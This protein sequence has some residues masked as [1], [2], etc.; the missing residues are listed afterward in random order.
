M[1]RQQCATATMVAFLLFMLFSAGSQAN[2]IQVPP[3]A[4]AGYDQTVKEGQTVFLD[5]SASYDTDGDPITF[6][7]TQLSGTTVTLDSLD[8]MYP[9][10]V[11]P[12]VPGTLV[13]QV[14][15]NDGQVSAFDSV[16]IFVDPFAPVPE[17]ASVLL[18]GLGIVGLA[19][20][21]RSM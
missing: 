19:W 13:F 6:N 8:P 10:F 12:M 1:T 15:V 11:A 2:A 17:P 9:Y 14:E 3:V 4:S 7:W 5:G 21:K 18:L 20:R 16:N